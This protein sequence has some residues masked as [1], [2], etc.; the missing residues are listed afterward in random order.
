LADKN[1][2]YVAATQ[3]RLSESRRKSNKKVRFHPLL[4][5]AEVFEDIAQYLIG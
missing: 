3:H 4:A 1:L 5:Y 2:L